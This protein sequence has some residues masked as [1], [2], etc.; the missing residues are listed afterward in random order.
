MYGR[1]PQA[2]SEGFPLELLEDFP[3]ELLL[4]GFLERLLE[5]FL[6]KL[7]EKRK[8]RFNL[9]GIS[10]VSGVIPWSFW[11]NSLKTREKIPSETLREILSEAPRKNRSGTPRRKLI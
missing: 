7:I 5:V 9:H 1:A 2:S 4:Y 8:F 10:G 6:D 11:C 3:V